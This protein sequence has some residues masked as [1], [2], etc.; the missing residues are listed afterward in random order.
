MVAVPLIMAIVFF[1]LGF[2]IWLV[3]PIIVFALHSYMEVMTS[4]IGVLMGSSVAKFDYGLLNEVFTRFRMGLM[5]LAGGLWWLVQRAKDIKYKA[6][7]VYITIFALW[8]NTGSHFTF[9]LGDIPF[10]LVN[11]LHEGSWRRKPYEF[12]VAI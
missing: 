8:C 10:Y 7:G 11:Y 9:Q 12:A 4:I 1:C 3:S 2:L 5:T 6:L